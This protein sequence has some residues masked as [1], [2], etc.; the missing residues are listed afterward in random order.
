MST[1]I[2]KF[3]LLVEIR[4]VRDIHIISFWITLVCLSS[5][6]LVELFRFWK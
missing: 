5:F 1:L 6:L 2:K 3:R 4:E